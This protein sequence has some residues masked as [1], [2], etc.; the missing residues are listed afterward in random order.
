MPSIFHI[1]IKR[2]QTEIKH[3]IQAFLTQPALSETAVENVKTAKEVLG[4]PILGGILPIV[5][6]RNACFMNNE[7]SGITVSEEIVKKYVGLDREAAE[8]LAIEISLEMIEKMTLYVDGYYLITPFKR[9]GLITEIISRI[10]KKG[11]TFS[12]Q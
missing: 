5:S 1:E 10:Q 4:V 12:N 6:H 7:I 2:A 3:G 11:Q 8:Q 9:I